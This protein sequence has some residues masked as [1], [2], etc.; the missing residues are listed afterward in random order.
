[1]KKSEN[2]KYAKESLD[3]MLK[4]IAPYM[5]KTP[6]VEQKPTKEWRTIGKGTIPPINSGYY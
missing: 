4:R 2:L 1:M 6:K 5:P 3:E